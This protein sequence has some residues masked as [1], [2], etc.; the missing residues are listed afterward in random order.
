MHEALEVHGV[1]FQPPPSSPGGQSGG[2]DVVGGGRATLALVGK[3]QRDQ[4][5]SIANNLK[6]RARRRVR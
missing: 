5:V 4:N 1:P 2:A 3:A 6:V